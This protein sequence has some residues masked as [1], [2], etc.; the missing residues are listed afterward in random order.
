MPECLPRLSYSGSQP[1]WRRR[2]GGAIVA[3][4]LRRGQRGPRSLRGMQVQLPPHPGRLCSCLPPASVDQHTCPHHPGVGQGQPHVRPG[5][6]CQT[7]HIEGPGLE[8]RMWAQRTPPWASGRLCPCSAVSPVSAYNSMVVPATFLHGRGSHGWTPCAVP[9]L[10]LAHA[11]P[12][13]GM[14]FPLSVSWADMLILHI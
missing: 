10:A 8:G 12:A 3:P 14:P 4:P 13:P 5:V 2:G 6:C 9:S 1:P 11:G 7:L